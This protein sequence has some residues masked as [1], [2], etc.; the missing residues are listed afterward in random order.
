MDGRPA[1]LIAATPK[2]AARPEN[3]NEKENL[4]YRVRMWIDREDQIISRNELEVI[5]DNS[6][7]QKGTIIEWVCARNEA[8]VC[9]LR[10]FHFRYHLRVL[11]L[12]NVRADL[13]QTYSDYK[14]FQVDSRLVE[15][16]K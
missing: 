12:A 11:K 6:R 7:M 10:E 16:P 2:L 3:A 5:T 14:R 9:L 1:Y 15:A 4:N 13:T 8:G